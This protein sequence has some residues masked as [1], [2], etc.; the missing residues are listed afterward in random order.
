ML[1]L[2]WLVFLL[3]L[4]GH[5]WCDRRILA[6]AKYWLITKG[7]ISHF[8][9][10]RSGRLLWPKITYN[11]QVFEQEYSS[12][13]LFL[14]TAHNNPASKYARLVAYR[15]A[16]AYE[17]DKEIDVYYNPNN[18]SQAVLDITIPRKLNIIISL[19]LALVLLH[20]AVVIA[21]FL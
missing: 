4:L 7:R 11:Y 5:F 21:R 16:V 1:D 6:K 19:L 10:A 15:A 14:D 20:L 17:D 18:P 12:E 3:Y 13:Y 2:I 8:E 9:W